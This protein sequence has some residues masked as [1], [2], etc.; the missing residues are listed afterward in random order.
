M[1][2]G[3]VKL[4]NKTKQNK[5]KKPRKTRVRPF[6]T[7]HLFIFRR[8]LLNV[9]SEDSGERVVLESWVVPFPSGQARGPKR[10]TRCAGHGFPAMRK[11]GEV[12]GG[13]AGCPPLLKAERGE[14]YRGTAVS[15]R[16]SQR[17]S[18][19]EWSSNGHSGKK[20]LS[21]FAISFKVF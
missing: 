8:F 1:W 20:A 19:A 17:L 4:K 2:A 13:G 10:W 21:C 18:P 7:Y 14:C 16:G 9:S 6:G 12:Q 15:L 5:N 11:T 3:L